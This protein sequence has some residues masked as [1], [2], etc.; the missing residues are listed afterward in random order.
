VS[1]LL[2]GTGA[3]LFGVLWFPLLG[4]AVR[5]RERR[6]RLARGTVS[7][8]FGGFI[9]F[10]ELVGLSWS[11]H[12]QPGSH[13]EGGRVVVA[14][15]PTLIDAVFLMWLFPGA[16]C[17][18]KAAHWRNPLMRFA[19]KAAGY[20]PNDDNEALLEEATR[21]VRAGRCLLLFPQGTRARPGEEPVFRRG[22]A[23]I[24]ARAGAELYP[25]RIRCTPPVLRK[26]D[27]WLA[28]PE[29]RVHFR[30]EALEPVDPSS[31]VAA[32]GERKGTRRLTERL[33]T[34]LLE[35]VE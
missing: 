12:G 9:R 26:G 23:V 20:L 35:G 18:V 16:D 3:V 33:S 4:L 28:V 19:V 1:F 8:L 5:D 15:H 34:L 7:R 11:L 25:V 29:R 14:N 13:A 17:V 2:F 31:W 6:E 22:A 30:I 21:R 24:A 10:M 27:A 32:S